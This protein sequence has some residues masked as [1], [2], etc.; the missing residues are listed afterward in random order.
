METVYAH[1]QNLV[2]NSHLHVYPQ[3]SELVD[4]LQ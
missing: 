2:E 1:L 4:K 3:G